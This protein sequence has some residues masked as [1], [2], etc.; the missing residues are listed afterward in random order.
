MS[1]VG[2]SVALL[3]MLG[4][5]EPERGRFS[6]KKTAYAGGLPERPKW[7]L[8]GRT[9]KVPKEEGRGGKLALAFKDPVARNILIASS[10]RNVG[11]MVVSSFLPV[12]FGKNFPAFKAEYA[13]LNA[14]ALTVMGL[15]A[16]LMGGMMADK[17]GK[18][19]Y[20]AKSVICATGCALSVPLIALGTL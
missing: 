10:L 17:F 5:K 19:H 14:G 8:V 9:K 13:F 12:F 6:T 11:G 2:I 15:T 4:I 16:S 1:V 3:T 20:L 7:L 18:K